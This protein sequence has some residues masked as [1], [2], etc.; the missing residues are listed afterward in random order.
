MPI[1]PVL[2]AAVKERER[3]RRNLKLSTPITL[4]AE[5]IQRIHDAFKAGKAKLPKEEFA[6]HV[7]HS[8]L[9]E[10]MIEQLK[11][12]FNLKVKPTEEKLIMTILGIQHQSAEEAPLKKAAAKALIE[13]GPRGE[14]LFDA[15][16][17]I[18]LKVNQ[19]AKKVNYEPQEIKSDNKPAKP[20]YGG[21]FKNPS[22][23]LPQAGN[24]AMFHLLI[25]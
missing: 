2:R 1:D 12:D 16:S 25:E 5:T 3:I 6:M 9:R 18:C 19:E 14:E 4:D 15:A 13:L 17:E 10:H 22:L 21:M 23:I 24:L 7:G 8:F 11:A 20:H